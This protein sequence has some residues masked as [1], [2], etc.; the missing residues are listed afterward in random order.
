MGRKKMI[1]DEKEHR[2]MYAK[3]YYE[4]NKERLS[5]YRMEYNKKNPDKY[6]E[7][8]KKSNINRIKK[9]AEMS[10]LIKK[11]IKDNEFLKDE[12]EKLKKHFGVDD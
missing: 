8:E 11:V 10:K 6:K 5:K 12:I 4:K 1:F 9:V 3:E 2:R 7:W